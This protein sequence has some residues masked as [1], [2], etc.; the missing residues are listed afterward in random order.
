[1]YACHVDL[2]RVPALEPLVALLALETLLPLLPQMLVLDVVAHLVVGARPVLAVGA[3]VVLKYTSS[4]NGETLVN[5][6][7]I[8]ATWYVYVSSKP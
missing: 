4:L 8:L 6:S 7:C 1:M 5:C 3:L 2:K